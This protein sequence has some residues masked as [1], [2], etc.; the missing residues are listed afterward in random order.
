MPKEEEFPVGQW[1]L[2]VRTARDSGFPLWQEEGLEPDCSLKRRAKSRGSRHTEPEPPPPPP[3]SRRR[4]VRTQSKAHLAAKLGAICEEDDGD[5]RDD[6][7][8]SSRTGRGGD[9]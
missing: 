9:L 4:R 6:D 8:V 3:S 5:G 2:P 1:T 7:T